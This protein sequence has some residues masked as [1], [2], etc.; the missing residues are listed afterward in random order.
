MKKNYRAKYIIVWE[1]GSHRILKDGFMSV[2][3]GLI[4]GFSQKLNSGEK[5]EDLGEVAIIPGFVNLHTHPSEIYSIKS[6][7][8]DTGSVNFYESSLV[9]SPPPILGEH[10]AKLQAML[11]LIELIKS[12]CTTNVIY[13][14]PRSEVEAELS[15]E[16]GIR[17]YVGAAIRAG[18]KYENDSILGTRDSHSLF[19]N[20]N[21]ERGKERLKE[22]ENFIKT[23]DNTFDGRVKAMVAPT[24]SMTC[25][26][27]IMK[28]SRKLADKYGVRITIHAAEDLTEVEG[29]ARCYGK[30]PVELLSENGMLGDDVIVAH[31][32]YVTGHSQMF[33]KGE[34]DLELLSKTGTTVAHSPTPFAR[35][36]QAFE[37]F[38]KYRDFRI[39]IGMGTDTF[40]SDMF[41]EMRLAAFMA[42]MQEKTTFRTTAKDL[43]DAATVNGAK[44]LGRNDIGKLCTGAKADFSVIDLLNIEMTPTRDIIKNLVYS[45]TRQSVKEVYVEGK[46][47]F[48]DGK[49]KNIDER[50]IASELQ[51]TCEN[52]WRKFEKDYGKSMNY[53][54]PMSY[55]I[56]K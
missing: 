56:Y 44:A 28:L 15:G 36:G 8:E 45:A 13:G 37:S 52:A 41:Q 21:D 31:C 47:V 32:V 22:A 54:Y 5:F 24:Q 1:D 2:E 33:I 11:N 3:N 4:E 16:F 20:F 23:Y 48:K 17:S 7:I 12:G 19:Y 26:P 30:T 50:E 10:G 34:K 51:E 53:F 49:V 25:T 35:V 27:E 29:C 39:N 9:D 18:D 42:K 46:A 14:G 40:P 38:A 55:P 6:F 43:F